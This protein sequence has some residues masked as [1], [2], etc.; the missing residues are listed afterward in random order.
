MEKKLGSFN[1]CFAL[2]IL[3]HALLDVL[4]GRK[5][6]G[7]LKIKQLALTEIKIYCTVFIDSVSLN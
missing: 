6:E 3:L 7:L 1:R 4:E 2:N 5:E